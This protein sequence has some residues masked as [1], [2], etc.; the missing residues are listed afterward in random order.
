MDKERQ[1]PATEPEDW[2]GMSPKKTC[3]FPPAFFCIFT[4]RCVGLLTMLASE[5]LSVG[6]GLSSHPGGDISG[7][8]LLGEMRGAQAGQ[9]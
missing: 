3:S 5:F 6:A 1:A 8:L 7:C 2:V 9:W 4:R